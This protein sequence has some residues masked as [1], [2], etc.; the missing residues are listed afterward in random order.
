MSQRT[1]HR[2][3]H[4]A[5]GHTGSSTRRETRTRR[6]RQGRRA[7]AGHHPPPNEGEQQHVW[8]SRPGAPTACTPAQHDQIDAIAYARYFLGSPDWYVTGHDPKSEEAYGWAEFSPG[9]GES[10]PSPSPNRARPA[11]VRPV[12]PAWPGIMI[13]AAVERHAHWNPRAIRSILTER[14]VPSWLV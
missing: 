9:E 6:F 3:Y 14:G 12:N 11:N 5:R 13:P 8:G 10:G 2:H 7:P 4:N 1:G